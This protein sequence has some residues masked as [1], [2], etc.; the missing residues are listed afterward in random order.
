VP[1]RDWSV[2]ALRLGQLPIANLQLKI[3]NWLSRKRSPLPPANGGEG[4][5]RGSLTLCRNHMIAVP[6]WLPPGLQSRRGF[7]TLSFR[8]PRHLPCTKSLRA[9][10]IC[11]RRFRQ[12]AVPTQFK[13]FRASRVLCGQLTNSHYGRGRT[14]KKS[15]SRR[16][17]P[18]C[19]RRFKEPPVRRPAHSR[20]GRRAGGEALTASPRMPGFD[21]E[22]SNLP[23]I[24]R[25][26]KGVAPCSATRHSEVTQP[27]RRV[28]R[29][30]RFKSAAVFKV[31]LF[32]LSFLEPLVSSMFWRFR[33]N[34]ASEA[35][36]ATHGTSV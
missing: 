7:Q 32:M 24:R 21:P 18:R 8:N 33:W 16:P 14:W 30:P 3:C 36:F 19:A 9:P 35:P 26:A 25:L 29:D 13:V 12:R 15:T 6:G 20:D 27:T 4:G 11:A 5:Y 34:R 2:F 23:G 17:P 22:E 10:S 1:P 31:S 28:L